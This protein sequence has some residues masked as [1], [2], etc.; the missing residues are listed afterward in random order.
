MSSSKASSSG[1]AWANLIRSWGPVVLGLLFLVAGIAKVLDP[2]SFLGSLGGYGV[3]GWMRTPV[4]LVLPAVEI[5]VAVMLLLRWNVRLA[6][7]AAAALMAVFLVAVGYGWAAG[8]LDECGCF[9]PMME[10][11]PRDAFLMD[12]AFMAIAVG[13]CVWTPTSRVRFDWRATAL[14]V[15]SVAA[16]GTSVFG[17]TSGPSGASAAALGR[18]MDMREVDLERGEHL[19]YLFHHECPHCAAM[20]PRVSEYTKDGALPPVVGLTY[21]TSG[22]DVNRYRESYDLQM[23][24]QVLPPQTFIRITGEG[25]VPQLVYLRDGATVEVWKGIL[26]EPAELRRSLRARGSTP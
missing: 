6:A 23:P 24:V 3:P 5:G 4:A 17:Y 26:P 1:P 8:T 19:L 14:A 7:T 9:G 18:T 2:W 12:L 11:E 21:E 20:S 16:L 22:S 25:S 13:V 15:A 10:R